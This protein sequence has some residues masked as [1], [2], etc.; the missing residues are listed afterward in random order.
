[1]MSLMV[2]T[3]WIFIVLRVWRIQ[4]DGQNYNATFMSGASLHTLDCTN[5]VP[6]MQIFRDGSHDLFAHGAIYTGGTVMAA[7]LIVRLD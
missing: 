1:M 5:C 3:I 6:V 7:F 2:L 4:N